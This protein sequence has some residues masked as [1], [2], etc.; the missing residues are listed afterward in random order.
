[1]GRILG[2]TGRNRD[3]LGRTY[4]EILGGN[5]DGYWDILGGRN[6]TGMYWENW[7]TLEYIL[8]SMSGYILGYTR[9]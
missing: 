2:H 6:I 5:W 8:G 9:I 4:W 1:M 3:I 7:D